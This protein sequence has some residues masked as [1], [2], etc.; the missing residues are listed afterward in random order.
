M[1]EEYLGVLLESG[2]VMETVGMGILMPIKDKEVLR[3]RG[4]GIV[5]DIDMYLD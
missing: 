2:A 3:R 5:S 4:A 1:L